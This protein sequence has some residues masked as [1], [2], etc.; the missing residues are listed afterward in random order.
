MNIDLGKNRRK[1]GNYI[2][3]LETNKIYWIT[4]G[5]DCVARK[6]VLSR[7]INA[8]CQCF[9]WFENKVLSQQFCQMIKV[10]GQVVFRVGVIENYNFR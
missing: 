6:D 8:S 7:K 3:D 2:K 4:D 5:K 9:Q 10:F 1:N